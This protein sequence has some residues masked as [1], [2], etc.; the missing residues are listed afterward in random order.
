MEKLIS[1]IGLFAMVGLAWLLSSQK[2][3]IS[4][5]IV[6][7][8]LLL[9]F[10]LALLV[11]K[12]P[13]GRLFFRATG[14]FFTQVLGYV[15]DGSR[16][17]FGMAREADVPLH[18]SHEAY[19]FKARLMQRGVEETIAEVLEKLQTLDGTVTIT[20]GRSSTALDLDADGWE[21][22][23]PG[24]SAR[25]PPISPPNSSIGRSG[26]SRSR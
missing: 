5:R 2:R 13:P 14:D 19:E 22:E 12:T 15:D 17:M 11:L 9:Q 25:R 4:L 20:I 10:A 16:F 18:V 8:G 24:G 3:E 26:R 1:L 21:S 23:A 7:G 6:V